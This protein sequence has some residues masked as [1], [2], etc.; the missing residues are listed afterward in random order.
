MK[1]MVNATRPLAFKITP[2]H[3]KRA[4]CNKPGEC[5]VAQAMQEALGDHFEG[6]EVGRTVVRVFTA[7]KE[8][9]WNDVAFSVLNNAIEDKLGFWDFIRRVAADNNL[10]P[11]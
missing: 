2:Q 6:F 3:V 1:K 10:R 8:R 7:G 5:V 11:R 4:V 9:G